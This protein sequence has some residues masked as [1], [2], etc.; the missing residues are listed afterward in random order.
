MHTVRST[1]QSGRCKTLDLPPD[2]HTYSRSRT[3]NRSI[4]ARRLISLELAPPTNCLLFPRI[5]TGC[6]M[7]VRWS[8][9]RT[10]GRRGSPPR[11]NEFETADSLQHTK[12]AYTRARTTATKV[13]RLG[14]AL[15][16]KSSFNTTLHTFS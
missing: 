3:S 6:R 4:T 9:H 12:G 13:T 8:V 14:T 1:S 11:V 5:I 15:S 16:S 2:N 7:L 10:R